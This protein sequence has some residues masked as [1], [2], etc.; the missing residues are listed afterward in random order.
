MHEKDGRAA[1]AGP[2][3]G[4]EQVKALCF[5]VIECGMD[6]GDSKGDVS[7]AGAASRLFDLTGDGRFVFDPSPSWPSVLR[8]QHQASPFDLTAHA[9]A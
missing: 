7:E 4:V 8:P 6:V 2:G 5:Q 9:C 3:R 1:R